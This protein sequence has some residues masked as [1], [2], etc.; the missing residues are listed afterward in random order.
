MGKNPITIQL[1]I[2]IPYG[3]IKSQQTACSP[4]FGRYSL[5]T[6]TPRRFLKPSG[7]GSHTK[8]CIEKIHFF[9]N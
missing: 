3:S 8:K 5:L 1:L 9:Y 6:S 7:C 2:S 4:D